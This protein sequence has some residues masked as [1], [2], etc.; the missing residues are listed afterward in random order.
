MEKGS[1]PVICTY[2]ILIRLS[3]LR[4]STARF[5]KVLVLPCYFSL[6][7]GVFFLV[8]PQLLVV[9]DRLYLAVRAAGSIDRAFAAVVEPV[10]CPL[11]I[12][13]ESGFLLMMRSGLFSVGVPNAVI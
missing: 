9:L 2:V 11:G 1:E 6:Q 12:S 3:F 10:L 13:M 5:C 4:E 8:F 7:P